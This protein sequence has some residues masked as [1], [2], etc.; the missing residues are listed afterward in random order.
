MRKIAKPVGSSYF[1]K[2]AIGKG[3]C[4]KLT[5]LSAY[6]FFFCFKCMLSLPAVRNIIK[7]YEE[8][9]FIYNSPIINIFGKLNRLQSQSHVDIFLPYCALEKR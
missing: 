9:V 7:R 5:E 1:W 2:S 8:N 3:E 6:I 4:E